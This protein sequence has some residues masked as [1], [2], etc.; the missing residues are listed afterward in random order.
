MVQYP[1]FLVQLIEWNLDLLRFTFSICLL[2]FL[3][4]FLLLVMENDVRRLL[5]A[6]LHALDN[7]IVLLMSYVGT[8]QIY[9]DVPLSFVP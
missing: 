2:V 3:R 6:L 8:H 1:L 5:A 7:L 4:L 9:V